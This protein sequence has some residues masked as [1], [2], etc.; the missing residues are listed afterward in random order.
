MSKITLHCHGEVNFITCLCGYAG[1]CYISNLFINKI[2]T[3]GLCRDHCEM[4]HEE[5]SKYQYNNCVWEENEDSYNICEMFKQGEILKHLC[6]LS[7][8]KIFKGKRML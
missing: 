8:Y 6:S 5:V 4:C 2:V 1:T 7:L 3:T